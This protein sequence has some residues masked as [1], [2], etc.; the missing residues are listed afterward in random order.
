[1][2]ALTTSAKDGRKKRM[3]FEG[4]RRRLWNDCG[5]QGD[6]PQ[7]WLGRQSFRS[8]GTSKTAPYSI[9]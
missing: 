9:Y 2:A 1:M 4:N 8:S 6:K 3:K 7:A 5:K